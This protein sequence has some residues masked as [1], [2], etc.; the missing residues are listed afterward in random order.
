MQTPPEILK[1]LDSCNVKP[2]LCELIDR[3]ARR[4]SLT[5]DPSI[6]GYVAVR[7]SLHGNVSGYFRRDHVDIA[8]APDRARSLAMSRNWKLVKPP[9]GE[10]GL[11]RIEEA[12]LAESRTMDVAIELLVEAVDKSEAGTPYEGGRDHPV[13]RQRFTSVP[14]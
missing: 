13:R 2:G 5:A 6:H 11:L 8:L 12:A 3:V 10:T 14:A 4:R 1:G 7:P 9:N